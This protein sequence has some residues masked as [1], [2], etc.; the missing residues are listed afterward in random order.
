MRS[1]GPTNPPRGWSIPW[2]APGPSA[3]EGGDA[4]IDS[5]GFRLR[6]ENEA[7]F[8]AENGRTLCRTLRT[9]VPGLVWPDC[10]QP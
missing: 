5:T 7:L 8:M 10:D 4:R 1:A 9:E 6:L 2:T 3:A